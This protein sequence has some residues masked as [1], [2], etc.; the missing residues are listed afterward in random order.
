MGHV[1][2]KRP[3]WPH[4]PY[5]RNS[6]FERGVAGVRSPA[7]GIENDHVKVLEQS[8]TALWNIVHIRQVRSIAKAETRDF[9]LA[10]GERNTLKH[11]TLDLNRC[12]HP[13][14]L[15]PRPRRIPGTRIE[16]VVKNAFNHIGCVIIRVQRNF[17]GVLKA[18]RP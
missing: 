12:P 11:R 16:G 2:K 4:A 3:P 15:H 8:Q 10:V 18:E 17:A 1:S 5:E 9:N 6:L 7:Q 14:H 13:I